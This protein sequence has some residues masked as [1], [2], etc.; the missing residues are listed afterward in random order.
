MILESCDGI[1][2]VNEILKCLCDCYPDAGEQSLKEDIIRVFSRLLPARVIGFRSDN[3]ISDGRDTLDT[4]AS[5]GIGC[6]ISLAME[7]DLP[8]ITR[9][10]ESDDCPNNLGEK[11]EYSWSPDIAE[12]CDSLSVRRRLFDYSRDYFIILKEGGSRADIKGV[13]VTEPSSDILLH[14]ASIKYMKLPLTVAPAAIGEIASFYKSYP[15]RKITALKIGLP[16]SHKEN[17]DGLGDLIGSCFLL[18][19]VQADSYGLDSLENLSTYCFKE[20]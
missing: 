3:S 20:W 11:V 15:Y 14:S 8:C 6:E 5:L 12:Y 10:I 17:D 1:K 7:N 2:T 4:R 16:E 9:F 13:V 19:S 18:E